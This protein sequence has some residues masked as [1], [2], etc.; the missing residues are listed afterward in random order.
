MQNQAKVQTLLLLLTL[1]CFLQLQN[2]YIN[3]QDLK[4]KT[5]FLYRAFVYFLWIFNLMISNF[6][7]SLNY[8]GL[9]A[10]QKDKYTHVAHS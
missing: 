7:C 3:M 2:F 10:M 6:I 9:L 5:E 4:K 1:L 8:C